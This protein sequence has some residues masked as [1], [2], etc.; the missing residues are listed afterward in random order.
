MRRVGGRPGCSL[1]AGVGARMP[2]AARGAGRG[3]APR[4]RLPGSHCRMRADL[5]LACS[6]AP[7]LTP[8][9]RLG[10]PLTGVWGLRQPR[11]EGRGKEVRCGVGEGEEKGRRGRLRLP[12][13]R[14]SVEGHLSSRPLSRPHAA[15]RH[16]QAGD[17]EG[18]VTWDGHPS[19][20]WVWSPACP[21]C[22]PELPAS[23]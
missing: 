19:V 5:S 10:F 23:L 3:P 17:G 15:P 14:G 16:A 18:P 22:L 20:N 7:S 1:D 2:R 11:V 4:P 9:G 21:C 12:M 6:P 13:T 8:G